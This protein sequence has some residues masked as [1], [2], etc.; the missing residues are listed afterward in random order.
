[1]QTKQNL[2]YLEKHFAFTLLSL[3][4]SNMLKWQFD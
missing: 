4:G 2:E 1:M 3:I